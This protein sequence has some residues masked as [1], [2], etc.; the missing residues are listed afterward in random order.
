MGS[1]TKAPEKFLNALAISDY[2]DPKVSFHS[3]DDPFD[4]LHLVLVPLVSSA[5]VSV[6]K[7][8][9]RHYPLHSKAQI[10]RSL[11]NRNNLSQ[12]LQSIPGFQAALA[13]EDF[14]DQIQRMGTGFYALPET[15]I[16]D[17][18]KLSS[19]QKFKSDDVQ[20]ELARDFLSSIIASGV[21]RAVF[22]LKVGKD[23]SL[24]TL[25]DGRNFA[26]T[27]QSACND[28]KISTSFFLTGSDRFAGQALGNSLEIRE[29]VEILKGTGPLDMRK[30]ALE[31][32]ADMLLTADK[33]MNRREAKEILK[34]A[35][36]TGKSLRKFQEI[37]EH[38]KGDSR[39]IDD[40]SLLPV[41]DTRLEIRSSKTGFI[42]DV[43][44]R[45]ISA[46]YLSLMSE[47]EGSSESGNKGTGLFILKK[48]GDWCQKN[49]ILAVVHL[50]SPVR[51]SSFEEEIRK[52]FQISESPPP[53]QP[54]IIERIQD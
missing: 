24:E 37:I 3:T 51:E 7:I 13:Q 49:E 46:V 27:L 47:T 44:M 9:M 18:Q 36:L 33:S 15:V 53:F 10:R 8:I 22:N 16:A 14:Q 38:Q 43:R 1:S 5:G 25:Q 45:E 21:D 19:S 30:L 29:A 39:I 26:Q 20:I 48:A 28:I 2:K 4:K 52:T 35:I 31:F 42:H 12:K 6:P 23:S 50:N 40:I 34:K 41:S 11:A 17:L 32:G 54:L